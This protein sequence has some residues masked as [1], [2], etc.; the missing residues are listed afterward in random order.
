M[1]EIEN[2]CKSYGH[3]TVFNHLSFQLPSTG[4][5]ILVGKN[6]SGKSTLLSILAGRDTNY[7]GEFRNNKD[8]ITQSNSDF[9]ASQ[10]V[11]FLPQD[12]LVFEDENVL[13]NVCLLSE[14]K[15]KIRAENCLRQV[16][17]EDRKE[18]LASYLSTGEKQR[19]CLARALYDLKDILLC[20]E[21][22]SNLD[23]ENKQ[24]ILNILKEVSKTHLV[25]FA[26][27]DDVQDF[28]DLSPHILSINDRK[29]SFS[30]A[31]S[32]CE[33]NQAL[34]QKKQS[35]SSVSSLYSQWKEDKKSHFFLFFISF[36]FV[37]L[38]IFSGSLY[39]SFEIVSKGNIQQDN[40]QILK[41]RESDLVYDSYL[42]SS[43]IF[44]CNKQNGLDGEELKIYNTIVPI[45][46]QEIKLGTIGAVFHIPSQSY[47]S[48]NIKLISG[49]IP[50]KEGEIRISSYT[51]DLESTTDSKA[52]EIKIGQN[53]FSVV[54][55][56]EGKD[57]NKLRTRLKDKINPVQRDFYMS[58]SFLSG[59]VFLY[60]N[61]FQNFISAFPNSLSNQKI[62]KEKQINKSETIFWEDYL[63]SNQS[64]KNL[65]HFLS[66]KFSSPMF[67]QIFLISYSSFI[68]VFL[69]SFYIRNKRRYLLK[70]YLGIS[71]K[72]L[73]LNNLLL[74]SRT[75]IFS[76]LF[77]IGI[78]SLSVFLV[79]HFVS[80]QLIS[81]ITLPVL[82]FCP[83]SYLYCI[84][85]VFSFVILFFTTLNLLSPKNISKRL[86]EVKK[87]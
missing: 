87:K 44:I 65:I 2:L 22:T 41:D 76:L 23:E 54:G 31:F 62:R 58:Y 36:F 51:S 8:K 75:E 48:K 21:I 67:Y 60:S 66:A 4:L 47:V 20:D 69:I 16:G 12:S 11:S 25:L 82:I 61:R 14:K 6:G 18:Q 78:G 9:F 63:L 55:V 40:Y 70:R 15:N 32:L 17:L 56:Y 35:F 79:S 3:Q 86:Y 46:P 34:S 49:R 33:K 38:T 81:K 53:S 29:I 39:Y 77:G 30:D 43:P 57:P 45:L 59:S 27:H 42:S 74:F 80:K 68:V 50:D 71:R 72:V 5:C 84:L 19:L 1:I 7:R 37:V 13:E 28:K 73:N 83:Y 26:T 85:I 52:K 64:G 24:I 10:F